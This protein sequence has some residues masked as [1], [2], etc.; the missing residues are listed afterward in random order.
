MV[1]TI[2]M[3]YD[4]EVLRYIRNVEDFMSIRIQYLNYMNLILSWANSCW[5]YA[6][7]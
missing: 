5:L 1:D 3:H 6:L 2:L 4:Y 7:V